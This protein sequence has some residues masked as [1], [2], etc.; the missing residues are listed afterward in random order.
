M[1][2]ITV[3]KTSKESRQAGNYIF[4]FSSPCVLADDQD[5]RRNSFVLS[6]MSAEWHGE[7][8][9]SSPLLDLE[10]NRRF[11]LPALSVFMYNLK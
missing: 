4:P 9:L 3:S 8:A 1:V 10:G 7:Q 2:K 11:L 6:R 5:L